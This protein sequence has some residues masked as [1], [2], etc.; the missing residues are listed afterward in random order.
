MVKHIITPKVN[1]EQ[2]IKDMNVPE[3]YSQADQSRLQSWPESLGSNNL[4]LTQ[5]SRLG[6]FL[7]CWVIAVLNHEKLQETWNI[8]IQETWPCLVRTSRLHKRSLVA[9]QK[10]GFVHLPWSP[11]VNLN[12]MYHMMLTTSSLVLKGMHLSNT[13]LLSIQNDF[14][15]T[16]WLYRQMSHL[17]PASCSS[18]SRKE[19]QMTVW[20]RYTLYLN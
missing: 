20:Q 18:L 14:V 12:H 10:Q 16:K 13:R 2:C 5:I 11:C 6:L 15:F 9:A 1:V 7:T 4:I 19:C 8:L 17:N 3:W